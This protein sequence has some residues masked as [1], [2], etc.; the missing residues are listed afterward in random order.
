MGL[1]L[2]QK[3]LLIIIAMAIQTA[4]LSLGQSQPTLAFQQSESICPDQSSEGRTLTLQ[5]IGL[6]DYRNCLVNAKRELETEYLHSE[7]IGFPLGVDYP[8]RLVTDSENRNRN[9]AVIS[10]LQVIGYLNI[11]TGLI[12]AITSDDLIDLLDRYLQP[13][14]GSNLYEIRC[15]DPFCAAS[16][17]ISVSLIA[18]NDEDDQI[19][20][21]PNVPFSA[22][23]EDALNAILTQSLTRNQ[24]DL[25]S[26]DIDQMTH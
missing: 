17:S 26:L 6:E 20:L 14:Q 2:D 12:Q 15:T 18:L 13:L 10:R 1:K 11:N 16:D 22:V 9:Q 19:Y 4:T 3:Q 25:N 21:L 7:P 23:L 8:I 5:E 24:F